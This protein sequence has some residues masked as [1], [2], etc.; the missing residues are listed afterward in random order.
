MTTM[1]HASTA[2]PGLNHL[3]FVLGLTQIPNRK[4]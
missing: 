2:D 1:L 4:L 3:S